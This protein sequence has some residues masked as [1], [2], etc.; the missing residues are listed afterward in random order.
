MQTD[1]PHVD[2]ESSAGPAST[3][4]DTDLPPGCQV[5]HEEPDWSSSSPGRE[6]SERSQTALPRPSF[7]PTGAGRHRPSRVC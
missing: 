3:A 4:V 1:L 6:S 5:R 2:E 7:L